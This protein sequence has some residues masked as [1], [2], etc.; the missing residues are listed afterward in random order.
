[1]VCI[2][3]AEASI[4][5]AKL[6][7]IISIIPKIDEAT[8]I[9]SDALSKSINPRI[10]FSGGKDSLVVRYLVTQQKPE[11]QLV[12]INTGNEYLE[13]IHFCRSFP[14]LIELTPEKTFWQCWDEYGAPNK[15]GKQHGSACCRWLKEKPFVKYYTENKVDLVFT[16]LTAAESRQRKLTL[17]RIGHYYYHKAQKGFTCH[18]IYNWS[19]DDVWTFIHFK[20]L[21]YNPIY[22][23]GIRRTG[24]RFCTSYKSWKDTT[25]LYKETDTHVIFKKMGFRLLKEFAKNE[26]SEPRGEQEA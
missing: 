9:I 2:K 22:D 7:G 5:R 4:K 21:K 6:K 23:M 20:G 24:C 13:T 8:K 17:S 15:R 26:I 19:E 25:S 10:S 18:P 3:H 12:W 11:T 14:N 16:G 1:M